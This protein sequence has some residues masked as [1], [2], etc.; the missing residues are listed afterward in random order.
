MPTVVE[1]LGGPL[2]GQSRTTMY[3][4]RFSM[5]SGTYTLGAWRGMVVYR[6]ERA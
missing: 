4:E 3:G 5:W 2:D 6:W 1:C